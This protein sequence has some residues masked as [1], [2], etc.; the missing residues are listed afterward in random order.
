[1]CFVNLLFLPLLF[2]SELLSKVFHVTGVCVT[3]VCLAQMDQLSELLA[4]KMDLRKREMELLAADPAHAVKPTEDQSLSLIG[5]VLTDR[6]LSMNYFRANLCRLL[7]PVKGVEIRS[8]AQN[9]FTMKFEHPLDR[10]NAFKGCPWVLDKP[11]LIL[12]PIDP[13]KKHFDHQLTRLP[14]VVRIQH[15]SLANRSEHVVRLIGII[16][17]NLWRCRRRQI[18]FISLFSVSRLL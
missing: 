1:M 5:W 7:R 15:L 16:W 9:K 18:A 13:L 14:I 17:V 3:S 6:D 8:I 2:F 12:E 4:R 10:K 11:A